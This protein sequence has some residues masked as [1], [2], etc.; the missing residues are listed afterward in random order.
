[1]TTDAT[2]AALIPG[3]KTFYP[4][5]PRTGTGMRSVQYGS[6]EDP[7]SSPNDIT[8]RFVGNRMFALDARTAATGYPAANL[9]DSST[10][11]YKSAAINNYSL[12]TPYKPGSSC[13]TDGQPAGYNYAT[14]SAA[15]S[16]TFTGAKVK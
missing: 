8:C 9:S 6:M 13:I 3:G 10:P 1:M 5:N 11:G 16:N 14:W 12:A 4:Y 15:L 2:T 7:T